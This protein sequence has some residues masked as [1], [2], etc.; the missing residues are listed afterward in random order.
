L[1]GSSRLKDL[2]VLSHLPKKYPVKYKLNHDKPVVTSK[3]SYKL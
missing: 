1:A 3:S 2:Q